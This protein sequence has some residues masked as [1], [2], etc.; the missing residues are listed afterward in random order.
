[1]E[2]TI[3]DGRLSAKISTYGAEMQSLQYDSCEYLWQGD[4]A[5]WDEH[6]PVL[7]PYV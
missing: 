1:M 5:Y 7:F 3:S 4:P 6:S 2:Y